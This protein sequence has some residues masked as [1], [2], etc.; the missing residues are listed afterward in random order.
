MI[1]SHYFA[2]YL[3]LLSHSDQRQR[4]DA[5]QDLFFQLLHGELLH[6]NQWEI[7]IPILVSSLPDDCDATSRRWKYQVGSF[8]FNNNKIL[9]DYCYNNIDKEPDAENRTWMVAI[10]VKNL[11]EKEFLQVL[12]EKDHRLS[13]EN[14]ELATYLFNHRSRIDIQGVFRHSDPLS[15]MWLASIGAYRNIAEQNKKELI[16][17]SKDLVRLTKETDNDEVLKHVMYAFCLQRFFSF[18][19]L[20]ILPDEYTKMGNQQKKWFFTLVW[21]DQN[22]V[23]SNIDYFRELTSEKHLFRDINPEVRIGLARGLSNCGYWA[24]LSNNIVRWYSHENA[25]SAIYYLT[26][27]FQRNQMYS[28]T[29]KE[30]IDFQKQNGTEVV[31]ELVILNNHI[32]DIQQT[33][34]VNTMQNKAPKIFISHSS[35]DKDYVVKLIDLLSDLGLSENQMFCS[36]AP[37]FGIPLDQDIY[38]YL[39]EQFQNFD[40]HVIYILSDNYYKSAACLNEMGAAWVLRKRYTSILLPGFQRKKMKG[41]IN[42]RQNSLKLDGD[43][44]DTKEKLGQLKDTLSKE[45]HLPKISDIRWEKK[46]DKFI[47]DISTRM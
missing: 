3:K 19:E 44:A 32:V 28:K 21:R 9:V 22:F 13:D 39:R 17:E 34:E 7:L 23:S 41:A 27:Y 24:D 14:V 30:V 4:I 35:Q 6:P 33:E 5:L 29:Y 40:L 31:K 11:S 12:S 20:S 42:P 1:N 36:S 38:E 10:L 46:R 25:P 43:L 45:F 15:M 8:S 47:K 26:K 2:H 16:I 37:G 18:K